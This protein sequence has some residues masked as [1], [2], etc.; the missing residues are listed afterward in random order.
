MATTI[1]NCAELNMSDIKM[2]APRPTNGG[3]KNVG[4]THKRTNTGIRIQLP[5]MRT[6]GATDYE[7]NKNFSFGLQF[8]DVNDPTTPAE[9]RDSLTKL[10]EFEQFLKQQVFD[11]SKEWPQ[12]PLKS[13]DMVDMIW[14]PMLKYPG[15]GEKDYNKPPTINVKLPC[16]E[17]KWSSELYDEEGVCLFSAEQ[18]IGES[19]LEYITKGTQMAAILQC[20]G[21]WIVGGKVGVVWK[22]VQAVAKQANTSITGKCLINL[23]EIDKTKF[24][25]TSKDDTLKSL[26]DSHVSDSE[27][28]GDMDG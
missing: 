6:Y 22:L 17:N 10:I 25:E 2:Y 26:S 24:I 3:G 13:I 14:T 4:L 20:G 9:Y 19:P 18:H 8:P 1:I 15:K 16:W 11:R 28:E 12:K 23:K 27:D 7:G 5:I 21:V